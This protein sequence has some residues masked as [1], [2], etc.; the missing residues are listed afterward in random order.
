[1]KNNQIN[2]TAIFESINSLLDSPNFKPNLGFNWYSDKSYFILDKT[3]GHALKTVISKAVYCAVV[4]ILS[5]ANSWNNNLWDAHFLV[6][7]F[8]KIGHESNAWKYRTYQTNVDKANSLLHRVYTLGQDSEVVINELLNKPTSQKTWNFY[9]NLRNPYNNEF[10][11]IDRHI[12]KVMGFDTKPI[13]AKNYM[14]LSNILKEFHLKSSLSN[15]SAC[16][17]QAVLW[18]NYL[19]N[20][21]KPFN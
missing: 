17:F 21:N 5:P 9:N 3:Q 19:N 2:K 14:D 18:C 12:L 7:R 15:L 13:T 10:I 1:M 4:S 6:Y 20:Q 11:T 16:N 8:F